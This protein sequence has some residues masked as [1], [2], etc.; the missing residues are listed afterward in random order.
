MVTRAA[1]MG[2]APLPG[3]VFREIGKAQ[4]FAPHLRKGWR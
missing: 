2:I 1:I 4:A 3:H